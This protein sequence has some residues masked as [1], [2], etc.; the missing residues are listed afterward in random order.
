MLSIRDETETM[1]FSMFSAK[2]SWKEGQH[3]PSPLGTGK[4][5]GVHGENR[6]LDIV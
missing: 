5:E 4:Q 6:M 3:L 2:T 1:T